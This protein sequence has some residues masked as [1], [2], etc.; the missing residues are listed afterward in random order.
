MRYLFNFFPIAT[1]RYPKPF[2][3]NSHAEGSFVNVR[4]T[5]KRIRKVIKRNALRQ[6]PGRRENFP[7]ATYLPQHMETLPG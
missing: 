3:T 1:D 7:K 5:T 6:L 2:D 4:E